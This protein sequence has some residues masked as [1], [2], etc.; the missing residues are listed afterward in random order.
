MIFTD[1]FSYFHHR[2]PNAAQPDW[3]S[4]FEKLKSKAPYLR[5]HLETRVFKWC[6]ERLQLHIPNPKMVPGPDSP[7]SKSLLALKLRNC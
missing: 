7:A 2:L 5:V 4:T 3:F 6:E 1:E